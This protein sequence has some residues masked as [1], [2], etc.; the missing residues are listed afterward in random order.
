MLESVKQHGITVVEFLTLKPAELTKML[1]RSITDIANFQ[2]A[3]MAEYRQHIFEVSG[4]QAVSLEDEPF[5]FTTGDEGIDELLEGGLRTHGI[6]EI[7]GSSSTGKSQLLMQLA[8]CIQLSKEAGGLDGKCV[9]I[10]TE[11]DLPTRR[12]DEMIRLKAQQPGYE[13]VS[14]DNIFT[15]NCNDLVNQEHILNVQLPILIERNRDIKLIVVDSI[16]HHVRVELERKSFKDSQDNRHYVDKMA[17]NLLNFAV[18][19]SL[20]VVVANQVGDKP[21]HEAKPA[22]ESPERITTNYNYQLGWTV[23]WKESS[24]LYYQLNNGLKIGNQDESRPRSEGANDFVLSEDEDYNIVANAA[25][26]RGDLGTKRDDVK[27]EK[28][29]E[30]TPD[31]CSRT[32]ATQETGKRNFPRNA[33]P[34]FRAPL[35]RRKRKVDSKYPTLGLTWANHIA[36]RILLKKSYK[37]SPL[38]KKGSFDL[39][40][41]MDTS[42]FWQPR[43]TLKVVFSNHSSQGEI[44]YMI[45]SK[46]VEC[47][48]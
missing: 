34:K 3:L 15:V 2:Q 26:A 28:P 7:F 30:K 32:T 16:S 8:L 19:Y 33:E 31:P 17:Q 11:G 20:A 12:L 10:T 4:P 43:R 44:E 39:N 9:Y 38:I 41:V 1:P 36:T 48:P 27:N 6:T 46:G 13:R 35:L 25:L 24:I 5:T 14:Q 37:A 23:G 40:K 29:D 21:V 18:K 42:D 22:T 47:V 45:T